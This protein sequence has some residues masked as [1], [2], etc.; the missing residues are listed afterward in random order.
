M[1]LCALFVCSYFGLS[2]FVCVVFV[3]VLCVCLCVCFSCS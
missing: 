1:V 2:S 3:L